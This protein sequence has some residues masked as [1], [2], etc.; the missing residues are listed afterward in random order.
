M[1]ISNFFSTARR[2]QPLIITF[3]VSS[4]S[5]IRFLEHAVIVLSA[6]VKGY[7]ESFDQSDYN[8]IDK[9]N[10]DYVNAWLENEHP[11]RGDIKVVLL[12]PHQTSSVLL[13]FRRHDFVNSEGYSHWPFMSVHYWGENPIGQ[14]TLTVIFDSSEGFVEV[15]GVG[16]ELYGTHSTPEALRGIPTQCHPQ[17]SRGC[18]E[19]GP[20]NCDVC[21]NLRVAATL[22]C[23]TVC[24][25]GTSISDDHYGYCLDGNYTT[26]L[27]GNSEL[28][29]NATD[30]TTT[31]DSFEQS[32]RS[33]RH[34]TV[35]I[36]GVT[37]SV[38]V[39]LLLT[40]A[41]LLCVL[42]Y[43]GL[44]KCPYSDKYRIFTE[45]MAPSDLIGSSSLNPNSSSM[46][47]LHSDSGD[48]LCSNPAP[49]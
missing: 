2:S 4:N 44:S 23:V 22:E 36:V 10:D 15:S 12:S 18:S 27:H 1:K 49:V 8:A 35:V 11:R 14:W 37:T 19:E 43:V 46:N 26:D 6:E 25:P 5:T 33:L 28:A 17:C 32:Q 45:E 41:V 20:Q 31:A 9:S 40:L 24:P 29:A 42:V 48:E 38:A 7:S 13:P 47:T 30:I 34:S 21:R 3:N 39:I 16:L